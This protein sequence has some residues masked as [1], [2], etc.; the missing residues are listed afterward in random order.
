MFW[1]VGFD[2]FFYYELLD[3]IY[4]NSYLNFSWMNEGVRVRGGEIRRIRC[5]RNRGMGFKDEVVG[6]VEAVVVSL[7]KSR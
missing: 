5:W 1:K 7:G 2:Y 6:G 4:K 3:L